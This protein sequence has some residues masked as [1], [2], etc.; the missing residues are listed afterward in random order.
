MFFGTCTFEREARPHVFAEPLV[1]AL[2][3][4]PDSHALTTS[5]QPG[6][7]AWHR[8]DSATYVASSYSAPDGS[9]W[10]C[11]GRVDNLFDL[12]CQLGMSCSRANVSELV[13]CGYERWGLPI[14]DR[15]RGD[16]SIVSWRSDT[17]ELWLIGEMMGIQPLY[18]TREGE[19][20]RWSSELRLLQITRPNCTWDRDYL[21]G[22]AAYGPPPESTAHREIRSCPPGVRLVLSA[23]NLE[24]RTRCSIFPVNTLRLQR[25]VDYEEELRRVFLTSVADRMGDDTHVWSQLS[26]G[27]DSSSVVCASRWLMAQGR[28]PATTLSTVTFVSSSSPEWSEA[29]FVEAVEAHCNLSSTRVDIDTLPFM[30]VLD[31]PGPKLFQKDYAVAQQM[32]SSGVSTLLTG[33]YGDLV[34]RQDPFDV[35]AIAESLRRR[36]FWLALQDMR[37]LALAARLT[38]VDVALQAARLLRRRNLKH[39]GKPD[40][41]RGHDSSRFAE[42]LCLTHDAA[43][44]VATWNLESTALAKATGTP[45]HFGMLDTLY[46]VA[47]QRRLQAAPGLG[48]HVAHPFMSRAVIEFVLAIP[49]RVLCAPGET[50]SL[51]RRAF[52]T[53]VPDR[54]LRRSSK[55]YAAPAATRRLKVIVP[56]FLADS[57]QW[58]LADL[59]IVD[60]AAVERRLASLTRGASQSP[61]NLQF[62]L[63]VELWLRRHTDDARHEELQ[64]AREAA[65]IHR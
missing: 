59:N 14:F 45:E 46:R 63:G 27:L 7:V 57:R 39:L 36:E 2:N 21:I 22:C 12:S 37:T 56:Q 4:I 1:R 41:P 17:R 35:A 25:P 19:H 62:I 33:R 34:M 58:L 38:V 48:I 11:D 8:S 15:L 54:I 29:P 51:M 20:V 53:L 52:Q 64:S 24:Q 30:P 55:G 65:V 42:F 6:L 60:K 40:K 49:Q 10:T 43:Q 16:W 44:R 23:Q 5:V 3:G 26:G 50:R 47:A 13:W 31:A 28:V 61:R 32:R 18:Y 9:W